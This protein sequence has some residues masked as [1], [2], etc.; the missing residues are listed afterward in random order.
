LEAKGLSAKKAVMLFNEEAHKHAV[1]I[2][3]F[4]AEWE[5]K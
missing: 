2:A 4:P 3:A 1:T 5:K